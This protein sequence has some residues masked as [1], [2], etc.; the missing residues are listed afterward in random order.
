MNNRE[1]P[2]RNQPLL[3]VH[4]EELVLHGFAATNR[5]EVADA[6][7]EQ[8][9]QLFTGQSFS[10][11]AVGEHKTV[12]AGSFQVTPDDRGAHIGAQVAQSVHR[13]LSGV[14]QSKPSAT[15]EG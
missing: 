1:S 2:T 6:M 10:P 7:R 11:E 15:Y 12:D 8:L 4:I 13:G 3:K 5:Y 9:I 14:V